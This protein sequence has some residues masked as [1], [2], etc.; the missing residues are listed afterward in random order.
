MSCSQRFTTMIEIPGTQTG[1]PHSIAANLRTNQ[2]P[3]QPKTGIPQPG[4]PSR[5]V[6]GYVSN[7]RAGNIVLDIVVVGPEKTIGDIEQRH[8]LQPNSG[9]N[10]GTSPRLNNRAVRSSTSLR[11]TA[12]SVR[13]CIRSR[14]CCQTMSCLS[15]PLRLRSS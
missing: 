10:G 3:S 2:S 11:H 14:K 1:R 9:R 15:R 7:F 8:Q 12:L 6:F 13:C 5:S 4:S